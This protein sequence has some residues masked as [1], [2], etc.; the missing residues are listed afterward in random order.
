MNDDVERHGT[1]RRVPNEDPSRSSRVPPHNLEAEEALLGAAL[2]SSDAREALATIDPRDFYRPRHA[3][4]AAEILECVAS[5]LAVDAVTVHDGLV[6]DGFD[7][8]LDDLLGMTIDVPATSNAGRYASIVAD[9]ATLRRTIEAAGEIA[10]LGYSGAVDGPAA[11]TRAGELIARLGAAQAEAG[12]SLDW[13]DIDA[14][15]ESDLEP[16]SPDLLTRTD[17]AALLYAGKLHSLQAE[18]SVGKTWIALLAAIQILE[19]G[20]SVVFLDYEDSPSGILGRVLALG[21]EPAH[22]RERFR[23]SRPSGAWTAAEDADMRRVLDEMNPD[24][25]IIDGLVEA[26]TREGYSE[27]SSTDVIAYMDRVPRK[28]A[29]TGAAV[30]ILDHVAKDKDGRG[31]WARGTGAKL[32]AWDGAAYQV[33]VTHSF[34]R[35]NDGTMKL[36]VA[37]DRPGGVGPI[38]STAGV[39]S[40]MP[41]ADGKRV[42]MKLDPETADLRP[43]DS[44]RPTVLMGKIAKEISDSYHPLTAQQVKTLVSGKKRHLETALQRLMAEGYVAENPGKAPKTLRLEKPFSDVESDGDASAGGD[45]PDTG[46]EAEQ[47]DLGLEEPAPGDET[48]VRGPWGNPDH[49]D[50]DPQVDF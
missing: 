42:L 39:V 15:L 3:A 36:I 19:V 17:G 4:V 13:A 5:G 14:L 9:H 27:D 7:V 41:K 12:S 31:R 11:L 35:H 29:R 10:E 43:S 33:K 37:K 1:G 44:W 26:L 18:P 24:L 49:P 22:V 47:I 50:F 23:Y 20:G 25:V 30:L 40:I 38:G 2:I 6:R 34:D 46:D 28:I 45:G 48:V 21:A 32:G 16:E 8:S